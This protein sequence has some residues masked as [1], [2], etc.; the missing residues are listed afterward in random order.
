MILNREEIWQ[1]ECAFRRMYE[2]GQQN[3]KGQAQDE[4]QK[5]QLFAAGRS[6]PEWRCV[7][8]GFNRNYEP[9]PKMRRSHPW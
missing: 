8:T 6:V 7:D 4:I 3:S 1:L 9:N 2:L 5:L